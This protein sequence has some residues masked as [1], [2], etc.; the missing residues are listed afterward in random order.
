MATG[1]ETEMQAEAGKVR[2]TSS[3]VPLEMLF[4]V[5]CL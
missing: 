3:L 1:K 4:L 5:E 2:L